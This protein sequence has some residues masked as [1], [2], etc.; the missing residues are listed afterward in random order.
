VISC[1]D[2]YIGAV[3]EIYDRY[4]SI[5][6]KNQNYNNDWNGVAN[7]RGKIIGKGE[8]LPNGTYFFVL[9]FNDGSIENIKS[10][11]QIIR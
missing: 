8:K 1:I 7:Q 2:T 10:Y 9:R 4:G 6:Y 3:V 5:V 11:I